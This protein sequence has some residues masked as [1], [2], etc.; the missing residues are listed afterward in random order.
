MV[1]ASSLKSINDQPCALEG[2]MIVCPRCGSH[3]YIVCNGPRIPEKFNDR[4]VALEG[5]YA[6]CKCMPSPTLITAQGVSFQTIEGG[7]FADTSKDHT[8]NASGAALTQQRRKEQLAEDQPSKDYDQHFQIFD[9]ST[10]KPLANR[11]YQIL[12]QGETI[13]GKT[14]SEGKTEKIQSDK[15][16][17][18]KIEVF[19]E[20][21]E[22]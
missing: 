11:F 22:G 19:A 7:S 18:I 9:E 12:F 6:V 16:E 1:S 4:L 20:G 10:G 3:G 21:Y 5:D 8:S 15:A 14:D 13:K 17:E 2:D